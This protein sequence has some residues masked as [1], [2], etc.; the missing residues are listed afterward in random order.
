MFQELQLFGIYSGCRANVS[1]T[2]CIPLGKCKHDTHLIDYFKHKYGDDFVENTFTALGINFSNNSSLR[3]ISNNN[4]DNKLEK[5]KSW[6]NIWSKR[7]LTIMG[8]VTILKSL[9]FSQFTYLAI[10]LLMPDKNVLNK[11][12]TLIFNFLWGCK[13]DKIKREIITRSKQEGGL[14]LFSFPDFI[15]SLKLTLFN[16]LFSS[17]FE[18]PWKDIFLSQLKYPT[19]I[20]VSLES[21]AVRSMN[22][23]YTSD[24]E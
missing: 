20:R 19:Q 3:E 6:V 7:D 8:K 18:H 4:Y 21:G 9:V 16:K 11:I 17:N 1:K 13:R 22:Y 24:K 5:A 14:D 23:K 15:L 12:N 2:R 10:P